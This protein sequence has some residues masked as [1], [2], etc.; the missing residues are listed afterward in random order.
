MNISIFNI[1]VEN[2]YPEKHIRLEMKILDTSKLHGNSRVVHQMPK[3]SCIN[4]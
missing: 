4:R 2:K 1:N 3:G